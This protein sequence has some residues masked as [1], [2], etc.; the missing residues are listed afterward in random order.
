MSDLRFDPEEMRARGYDP[1]TVAEAQRAVIARAAAADLAVEIEAA[2]RGIPRPRITRSVAE[3][4]DDEWSLSEER[5]HELAACD[6]EVDWRDVTDEAIQSS[7]GF[8]FYAGAEGCQFYLPAYMRHY[9]KDFQYSRY[10]AVY[11][12]CIQPDNLELLD[13]AQRGCVDRFLDLC[14]QNQTP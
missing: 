7:Q 3:G 5:V 6:A 14:H 13:E 8:F 11:W 4:Y 9:L 10:D 1:Q 2:F 12:A